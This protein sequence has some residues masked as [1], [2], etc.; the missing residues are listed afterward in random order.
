MNT[1]HGYM[2]LVAVGLVAIYV[3]VSYEEKVKREVVNNIHKEISY[4]IVRSVRESRYD[5]N[6]LKS[7]VTNAPKDSSWELDFT[8]YEF[9]KSL[10]VLRNRFDEVSIVT[11][12]F[13]Y[14]NR[15][16]LIEDADN[17]T[18]TIKFVD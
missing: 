1:L 12:T 7:T 15:I 13:P 2:G 16:C 10:N 14:N 11:S 6:F 9:A 18:I 8:N 17:R 4:I 5:T 3:S